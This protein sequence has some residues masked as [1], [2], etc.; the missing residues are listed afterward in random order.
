LTTTILFDSLL[1][2]RLST[3]WRAIEYAS[4][5]RTRCLF[6]IYY[7]ASFD[8]A[9]HDYDFSMHAAMARPV[10]ISARIRSRA[11]PH[12]ARRYVTS[13]KPPHQNA[14]DTTAHLIIDRDVAYFTFHI[15]ALI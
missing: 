4:P 5:Q 8:G 13:L 3:L 9:A 1:H 15:F 11:S 2:I 7:G 6:L 10:S 12:A 14:S